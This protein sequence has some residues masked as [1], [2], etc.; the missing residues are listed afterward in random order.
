[1]SVCGGD[2][3]APA[4]LQRAGQQFRSDCCVQDEEVGI[5]M[6]DFEV[7]EHDIVNKTMLAKKFFEKL[8]KQLETGLEDMRSQYAS[9]A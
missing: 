9:L 8:V 7:T 6:K 1:M 3:T 2:Y 4:F 5:I